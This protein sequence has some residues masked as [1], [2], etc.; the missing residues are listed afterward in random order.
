MWKVFMKN[1]KLKTIQNSIPLVLSILVIFLNFIAI[2]VLNY[3]WYEL[4]RIEFLIFDIFAVYTIIGFVK[5]GV[6]NK[7]AKY[8]INGIL[9]VFGV[10]LILNCLIGLIYRIDITK[11]IKSSDGKYVAVIWRGNGGALQTAGFLYGVDV[12]NNK[13]L[14]KTS[15]LFTSKGGPDP[16]DINFIGTENTSVEIT[17]RDGQ[18]FNVSFDKQT[19]QP[20][21][22]LDFY[23]GKKR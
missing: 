22:V 12:K 11:K 9:H 20:D 4:T 23:R 15:V 16:Q 5:I 7:V 3:A 8:S 21:K 10:F 13:P 17:C 1:E 2:F 18:V 19:L 14:S 6:K